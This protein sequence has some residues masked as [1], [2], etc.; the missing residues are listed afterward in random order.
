MI[1]P[2]ALKILTSFDCHGLS[3]S[4]NKSGYKKDKFSD[5]QFV[6]ITNGGQFAYRVEY[7]EEETVKVAKVFLSYD[8]ASG[9]VT[10]DY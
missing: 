4:I 6:G 7:L 2:S 1:T 9:K 5:S 8:P 10:A 3:I